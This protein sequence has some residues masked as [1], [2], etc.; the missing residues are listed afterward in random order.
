M[1]KEPKFIWHYDHQKIITVINVSMAKPDE[2][3][4]K[5]YDKS[6]W[7]EVIMGLLID[8]NNEMEQID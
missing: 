6:D 7:P 4:I 3:W 2:I 5:K 8:N 1:D